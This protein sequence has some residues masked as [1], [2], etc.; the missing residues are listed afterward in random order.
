MATNK[1][2]Q[3][4]RAAFEA[5]GVYLEFGGFS[6]RQSIQLYQSGKLDGTEM[7]ARGL[8]EADDP[9]RPGEKLGDPNRP[10]KKHLKITTAAL[11]HMFQI[12]TLRGY[13]DLFGGEGAVV[14]WAR[15]VA[16]EGF[17]DLRKALGLLK[18]ALEEREQDVMRWKSRGKP[19]GRHAFVLE[20]F[21][22]CVCSVEQIAAQAR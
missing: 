7:G 8:E 10:G 14:H 15:H 9:N 4:E 6:L 16:D 21:R 13:T 1:K 5:L 22:A 19:C 12:Q 17:G 3:F 20:Q 11:R 2:G 18:K